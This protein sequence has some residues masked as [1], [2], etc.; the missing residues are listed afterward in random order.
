MATERKD[1]EQA[2]QGITFQDFASDTTLHGIKGVVAPRIKYFK[3]IWILVLFGSLAFYIYLVQ[4]SVR[5]FYSYPYSTVYSHKYVSELDFP[6]VTIC[7][8]VLYQ[9]NKMALDDQHPDF[10][11]FGLD[12]P[13][14]NGTKDMRNVS[15]G[16]FWY[17]LLTEGDPDALGRNTT[18][19]LDELFNMTDFA[20]RFS[21]DID[22]ESGFECWWL[23]K[24]C[25]RD[26]FFMSLRSRG[27]CYTFNSVEGNR[28]VLKVNQPGSSGSLYLRFDISNIDYFPKDSEQGIV[29]IL[30]RPGELFDPDHEGFYTSPGASSQILIYINKVCYIKVVHAILASDV[31]AQLTT[32][33]IYRISFLRAC[34][35][36]SIPE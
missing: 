34:L 32:H 10:K 31:C 36:D 21:T 16:R 23:N 18:D 14:C 13:A 30:H 12:I 35:I 22:L 4:R 5:R 11:K 3:L 29:V 2:K 27:F 20:Q 26:Y 9:A 33:T 28:S 1:T 17:K 7:S 19:I 24:E 6:A 25:K 8:P 15:C